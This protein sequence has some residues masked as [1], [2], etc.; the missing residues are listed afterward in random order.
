M[1]EK[2]I[3][4]GL[5]IVFALLCVSLPT[6]GGKN[7]QKD[8]LTVAATTTHIKTVVKA[9]GGD[10]V[11]CAVL[12]AGGMCPGH[13]DISPRH[14]QMLETA[15]FLLMH[16]WETWAGDLV[17]AA[18]NS[19]LTHI[20]LATAG[21]AMVPPVHLALIEEITNILCAADS[22]NCG[23]YIARA[24]VYRREIEDSLTF[25]RQRAAAVRNVPLVC[26]GHQKP[27]LSWLGCRV[28][29][30]YGRPEEMTPAELAHV[31]TAARNAGAVLVVDNMQS[32]PDAGKALAADLGV[33]HVVISNFPLDGSYIR[34]LAA[35]VDTLVAGLSVHEQ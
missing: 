16:G 29:A 1:P 32:G 5:I 7:L 21:N 30:T 27:L 4:T 15:D 23:H 35:N 9:V 17:A 34:T 31:E 2:K 10:L 28:A 14:V 18:G 33:P 6:C 12:V 25:L 22:S 19:D 8:N 20:R 13:F 11:D 24:A 26:S 3:R